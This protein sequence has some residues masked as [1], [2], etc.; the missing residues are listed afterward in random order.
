M[1]T[2]NTREVTVAG[3]KLWQY[4]STMTYA[5]SRRA[6]LIEDDIRY[7]VMAALQEL[8]HENPAVYQA[9]EIQE[10]L[11][12]VNQKGLTVTIEVREIKTLTFF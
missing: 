4:T 12:M 8:E 1:A 7:C 2:E 11:I 3:K 10:A 9:V 5:K 6:E